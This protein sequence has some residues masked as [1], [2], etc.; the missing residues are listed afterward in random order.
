MI[1]AAWLIPAFPVAGFV[2]LV[3][4][5][6]RLGEP[7]AGWLATLASA[8]AFVSTVVVFFGLADLPG[9]ERFHIQTLFTWIAAGSFSVDVGLL[10]D[11]L[12]VTMCLFIT[13]VGTLIHLYSIGYM[14]GDPNFS[15]F[16]IYLN[17]FIASMIL[18]VLGDNLLLT[19]LGWEGVGACSYLLIS[20]WFTDESNATAGKKAFVTNRVGDFGYMLATFFIFVGLGSIN[21]DDI[22]TRSGE[23]STRTATFAV[24]LFL[25]AAAGKS[26]QLP[27]YVWLPDAMAGPTPVSALIHAATMVTSG[28]FLLTRLNPVL[29]EAE[30]WTLALIAWVGALTALFAATVAVAQTDIKKVLAYSTVSQLGYL[31]LAVGV[32]GYVPAIFHMITHAF[33]KAL[34]FLGSGSV[35]HGLHD[36]QDMRRMGGLQKFMPVT[37][38]TFIVGWL[39]IAGVPPF[40]GFWSKDEILLYAWN[41][42]GIGGKA[43]WAIGL[44][45]ALLTAFYMT[46]LVILTF[47]GR[48]RYYDPTRQEI[49][50]ALLAR[51]ESAEA[52]VATVAEAGEKIRES[53]KKANDDSQKK[54]DALTKAQATL[55][56][57]T[58]A[59]EA[60]ADGADDDKLVKTLE[61]ATKAVPKAESAV[62]KAEQKAAGETA[63]INDNATEL[64]AAEARVLEVEN[65]VRTTPRPPQHVT[66][67]TEP[68]DIGD[69]SEHLPESYGKRQE[70]EPHE[71]P[72]TMTIPLIILASLAAVGGA[73][74]LPFTSDL[75]FLEHWLEP[76]LFGH[77][78]EITAG[79]ATKWLLAVVAVA[80]GLVAIAGG[81]A[82][83]LR[84]RLDPAQIESRTL[85]NAWYVDET[86]ANF[87]GGPGRR[88][89]EALAW[90]DRTVIDGT[91]RSIGKGSEAVGTTLRVL[92]PGFVR[93][94]AL[95]IGLGS[96]LVMAWFV[97]RLF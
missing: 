96:V 34:L 69:L 5:G 53:A 35:I 76:S 15:K 31:F 1:D 11:P 13:G 27:L 47:F 3:L 75:H 4:F 29:A 78:T 33:F 18:L 12:S 73:L 65:Q 43:L 82:V 67:L 45:T 21:Y 14:H 39:A 77:E 54:R 83:Y 7:V 49:G 63:K 85:A 23:L 90:F 66:A 88:L 8:G 97:G 40:S 57:A 91:I 94:Y 10:V 20:F 51:I 30:T 55:V 92:Q 46:R 2:L 19:F 61:K 44:V 17:L 71:S 36:E 86:Y 72:R 52:E 41:A 80:G 48:T 68:V 58:G 22:L 95:G 64:V 60:S 62:T 37:A 56:D 9:E 50:Q 74:N 25:L 26:A 79:A 42:E 89:F 87:M 59:V 32:G 38:F 70:V 84:G 28:V 93:S 24:V 6:R 16:F 81:F